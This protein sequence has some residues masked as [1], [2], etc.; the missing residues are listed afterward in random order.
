MLDPIITN[1][2]E[3][4]IHRR[5]ILGFL[6]VSANY[7]GLNELPKLVDS[8]PAAERGVTHALDAKYKYKSKSSTEHALGQK[9]EPVV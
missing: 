4:T 8:A 2:G 1:A 7:L 6:Q 3:G 9:Y 5:N